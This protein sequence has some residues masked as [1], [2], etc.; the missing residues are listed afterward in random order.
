MLVVLDTNVVV[1]GF[2]SRGGP[3]GSLLRA[4]VDGLIT[5][6]VDARVVSEYEDVVARPRI[7]QTHRP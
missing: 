6:V 2:M 5:P 3:P 4:V 7:A 1:S